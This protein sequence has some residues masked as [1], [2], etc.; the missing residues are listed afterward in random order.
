ML[1]DSSCNE[2]KNVVNFE[3]K[4]NDK[5]HTYDAFEPKAIPRIHKGVEAMN[6][7]RTAFTICN[8]EGKILFVAPG[9][10]EMMG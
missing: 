4:G 5:F 10:T 9:F 3:L 7:G 6:L 1:I 8:E 2:T